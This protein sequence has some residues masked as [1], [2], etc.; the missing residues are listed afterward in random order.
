M[1]YCEMQWPFFYSRAVPFCPVM[2]SSRN[3]RW[4]LLHLP[5]KQFLKTN[6]LWSLLHI[7]YHFLFVLLFSFLDFVEYPIFSI[8]KKVFMQK[9]N[10]TSF[11]TSRKRMRRSNNR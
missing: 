1:G 8:L 2:G 3:V 4:W 5:P 10:S 9:K 7:L 6:S 11:A